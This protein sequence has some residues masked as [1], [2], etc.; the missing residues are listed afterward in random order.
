MSN[1]NSVYDVIPAW[2]ASTSYNVYDIVTI[3]GAIYYAL[4]KHV[5]TSSFATDLAASKWGGRTTFNG[6]IKPHFFWKPSYN[7]TTQ[8]EPKIRSIKYGESYEQRSSDG[9]NNN[10]IKASYNFDLR[11]DNETMAILH[12]LH[13]RAAVESFFFSPPRPYGITKKFICRQ[14]SETY[15]FSDNHEIKANFEEV[16]N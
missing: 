7:S 11:T 12:F 6:E 4:I 8:S 2:A 9:I 15:S 13:V 14:W 3:N 16:A 10:L 5:S 1:V